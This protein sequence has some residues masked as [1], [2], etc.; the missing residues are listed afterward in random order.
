[1]GAYGYWETSPGPYE[2]FAQGYA[3]TAS[4]QLIEQLPAFIDAGAGN[5]YS[6]IA[7]V[8][9]AT[10]REG[11]QQTFVGCYTTHKV[12]IQPDVWHLVRATVAGGG[13]SCHPIRAGTGV[14]DVSRRVEASVVAEAYAARCATGITLAV[15]WYRRNGQR[16]TEDGRSVREQYRTLRIDPPQ[17]HHRSAAMYYIVE[18]T[19][20]GIETFLAGF[21]E[22]G[23]AWDVVSRLQCEARRRRRKVRYEVR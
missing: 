23:E 19:P 11:D 16:M 3:D 12:N 15:F 6:N 21:E 4:V 14:R 1:M 7:T 9:I 20:Q 22:V 8:L 18:I 17:Q 10:T 2:Q 13:Q 5:A